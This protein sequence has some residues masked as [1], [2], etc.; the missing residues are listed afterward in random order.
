M[1]L[2]PMSIF[3]EDNYAYNRKNTYSVVSWTPDSKVFSVNIKK[4][5]HKFKFIKKSLQVIFDK[6]NDFIDQRVKEF[7]KYNNLKQAVNNF[8]FHTI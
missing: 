3:G 8:S 7:T 2:G 1:I 5:K 6:R 4:F